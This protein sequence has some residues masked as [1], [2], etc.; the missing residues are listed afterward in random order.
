MKSGERKLSRSLLLAG[1][2]FCVPFSAQANLLEVNGNYIRM[3]LTKE[4]ELRLYVYAEPDGQFASAL[5]A[6]DCSFFDRN[7]K[8]LEIGD[9]IAEA[10]RGEGD[11]L[12]L[13]KVDSK[14]GNVAKCLL[15]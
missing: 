5:L 3:G 13:I 15:R 2:L 4:G 12:L 14:T 9:F 10:A 1:F 8:P 7:D 11:A 6:P